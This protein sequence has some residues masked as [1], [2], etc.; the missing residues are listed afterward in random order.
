MPILARRMT[1]ICLLLLVFA[2]AFAALV[3]NNRRPYRSYRVGAADACSQFVQSVCIKKIE[4][5][6]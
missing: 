5:A 4:S 2:F 6:A 1:I 3:E